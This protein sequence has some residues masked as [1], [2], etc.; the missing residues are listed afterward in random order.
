MFYTFERTLK[1]GGK[2]V[3]KLTFCELIIIALG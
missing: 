2:L 1:D 3:H